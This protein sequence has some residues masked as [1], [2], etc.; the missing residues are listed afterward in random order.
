MSNIIFTARDAKNNFGR[1]LDEA[2]DRPVSIEKH[3]RKVA[4]VMSVRAYE[5]FEAARDSYWGN[6]A[7]RAEKQGYIGTAKSAQV[8]K[9]A[10]NARD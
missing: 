3:G 2:R 4:V 1:L 9:K 8:L 7:S 5:E 10:L 6:A